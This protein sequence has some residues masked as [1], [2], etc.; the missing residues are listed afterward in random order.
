MNHVWCMGLCIR[1]RWEVWKWIWMRLFIWRWIW[2][3]GVGYKMEPS[4]MDDRSERMAHP[5]FGCA[6][7]NPFFYEMETIGQALRIGIVK[8]SD[9][10]ICPNPCPSIK[11]WLCHH[12]SLFLWD[13]NNWTCTKN[14][15]RKIFWL[16]CLSQTLSFY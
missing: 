10:N 11:C 14:G 8:F 5:N 2:K 16:K 13:G 12:K 15:N 4:P 7:I 3:C 1:E 9:S 6:T